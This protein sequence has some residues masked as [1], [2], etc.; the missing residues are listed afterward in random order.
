MKPRTHLT[1]AILAASSLSLPAAD[2]LWDGGNTG[3]TG[4]GASTYASGTWGTA[5]ANWDQGAGLSRVAWSNTGQDGETLDNA[6]FAGPYSTGTKTVTIGSNI[7]VNQIQVLTGSTVANRYD[8]GASNAQN[9][10]AITFGGSYSP[11][12][13]AITGSTTGF[14]NTNF[15][16]KITGD[17]STKGGLVLAHGSNI[18]TPAASGRFA[19][20][21][22]NN[23]FTGDIV[24]AAGNF[25]ITGDATFG[26][27]ANRFILKGGALFSS[28]ATNTTVM[29]SRAVVVESTSGIATNATGANNMINMSGKISGSA[30]LIRYFGNAGSFDLKLQG[31][32]SEFT[33]LFDNRGHL[34]TIET[35]ATS[36]GTWRLAGGTVRLN[37]TDNTHI[38]NGE[39]AGDLLMAGGTLDMNG[40]SETINGLSGAT[41]I[42]Q[43]QLEATTSTLTL[44]DDDSTATF[45]GTIR[46][47][48]GTGG[49]LALTKIGS[50]TQ[51]LSG[52][53]THSGSTTVSQGTLA[54]GGS[55][56]NSNVSVADGT[57][58]QVTTTGKDIKSLS[59]AG[60]AKLAAPLDMGAD[61]LGVTDELAFSGG[62]VTVFPVLPGDIATGTFDFVVAQGG[63]IGA[64]GS[65]VTDFSL[66]GPVRV[67]GS[68]AVDVDR[69]AVTISSLGADLV[70]NNAGG[71]GNGLWNVNSDQNFLNGANGDKFLGLDRV[72]FGPTSPAGTIT[73]EGTLNPAS[74]TVNSANAFTFAG[75]G[76][77][78]GSGTLTKTG[79]GTLTIENTNAITGDITVQQGTL[80]LAGT[81]GT[82]N[83]AI[84]PDA[85][86]AGTGSAAGQVIVD[87]TI[88][89]GAGIGTLA[90]GPLT[91]T[92][93]YN[94]EIAGTQADRIAVT[95]NLNLLD[96]T[97]DI[98][99]VSPP[100]GVNHVILTYTG[101]RTG[102][103]DPA[104]VP[105]GH[106]LDYSEP[107]K[108]VLWPELVAPVDGTITF[109]ADQGYP[110]LADPEADP[111]VAGV[112][113]GGTNAP[114]TGVNGW[115]LST[116][117]ST[118]RMHAAS[119]SG[120]YRGGQAFG[121]D[122]NGTVVSGRQGA[123][124]RAGAN[125][126][127]FDAPYFSGTQVGFFKD[128]NG[129]G[130]FNTS[131]TGM[132]FGIGGSPG[133]FNYRNAAFGTENFGTG[134]TGTAGH[135]YRFHITIGASAASQREI[136]MAVRNLTT[137]ADY[138][139]DPVT[140]G[141]QSWS[142][143]VTDAQF[144]TAPE[145]ADGIWVR[146]TSSARVDN[147]RATS[148]APPAGGGFADWAQLNGVTGGMAGDDDKDGVPNG[149]EFFMG[150]NSSGFTAMPMPD[151]NGTI[152]WPKSA[153]YNGVYG[154]DWLI[155][156]SP[157]LAAELWD[158]VDETD[159]EI[160]PTSVSYTL[161]EGLGKIF[162]RLKVMGPL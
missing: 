37:T 151:E 55:L 30:N 121:S 148:V 161:P 102:A 132:S 110:D 84:D 38:A 95:G 45:G 77:I 42:I 56:P 127:A 144:G 44:G 104:S 98:D 47:N 103:I 41:G 58:F 60:G 31:D 63:I 2:L 28:A 111:V 52:L 11:S 137:G 8:I 12:F 112:D 50:G 141:I 149:I 160:T 17:L 118:G 134:F 145:L 124:Q 79:T 54:V 101:T 129:D 40:K 83:L 1:F 14:L 153:A 133:R 142:F 71:S 9:D 74:V 27:A 19:F 93:I 33:G 39:D 53:T 26:A 125:S 105:A 18:T 65:L 87:G 76:S 89:P 113:P 159:L 135:W 25:G 59:L 136:V 107:G 123:I 109:E 72:T 46:D 10:F 75:S 139:F 146:T 6:S 108:V 43:N 61:Y 66:N 88:S 5:N 69:I 100:T 86:L 122:N 51:T 22:G 152:T 13:P 131:E 143:T 67:D 158:P 156:T 94:C 24:L 162:A 150:D 114:F 82:G 4:D 73:L 130:L 99:F 49:T 7:T 3:G 57:T 91:L 138:D 126:L 36:A 106:V 32:M 119:S 48:P 34:L 128:L 23:N 92:G 35:T 85:T 62:T 16:A 78:S 80:A 116:S 70:W 21:N 140:E 147:L 154:T 68:A 117:S 115:S 157:S 64:P 90:T 81:L 97:L 155:E 120:E 15:N 96:S 29:F 20:T